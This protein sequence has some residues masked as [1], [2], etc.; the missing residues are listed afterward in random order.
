MKFAFTYRLL[1]VF[2]FALPACNYYFTH[3]SSPDMKSHLKLD[4]KSTVNAM[5]IQQSVLYSCTNCHFSGKRSPR[6]TNIE[7]IRHN[8]D[9]VLK[10][11]NSNTMPPAQAGFEPL[12][13]C[14]KDILASWVQEGMPD[15][16]QTLILSVGHCQK[17]PIAPP[18]TTPSILD[19]PLNYQTFLAT[20]L[21]PKCLH[22][23][24][25][26][27]GVEEASEYLLYP[28]EKMNSHFNIWGNETDAGKIVTAVTATNEHRMPPPEDG[29]PLT[30]D[31]VEFIKRWIKAGHSEN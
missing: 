8:I 25:G 1:M 6:L 29:A 13:D 19:Q 30:A 14:E 27:S 21:R 7:D 9:A 2:I 26:D 12:S 23:H 10:V 20:I 17:N 5:A 4:E 24:N 31:E 11:V 22:C 18:N 15:Q 3:G 28:Y 16:S